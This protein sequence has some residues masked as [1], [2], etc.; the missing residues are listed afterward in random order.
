MEIDLRKS[1]KNIAHPIGIGKQ[2]PPQVSQAV[3]NIA[4]SS[5]AGRIANPSCVCNVGVELCGCCRCL[6]E[7]IKHQVDRRFHQKAPVWVLITSAT[8]RR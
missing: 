6:V 8:N 7:A 3:P 1:C 2:K 5:L 4:S